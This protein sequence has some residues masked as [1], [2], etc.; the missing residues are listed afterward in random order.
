[1]VAVHNL[2][3]PKP[4]IGLFRLDFELDYDFLNCVTYNRISPLRLMGGII[5][6]PN[7][8]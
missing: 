2:D 1:M 5:I 8:S 3:R 6:K 7:D 4:W